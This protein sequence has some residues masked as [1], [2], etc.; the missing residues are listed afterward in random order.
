MAS[1]QHPNAQDLAAYALG[2][3]EPAKVAEIEFH[4]QM[5]PVCEAELRRL[6]DTR[7]QITNLAREA[8]TGGP[9]RLAVT[10]SAGTRLVDVPVLGTAISPIT[11]GRGTAA[12]LRVSDERCSRIHCRIEEGAD[13]HFIVD[14]GSAN[15]TLVNGVRS[16][17]CALRDGDVVNLGNVRI[18]YLAPAS[19]ATPARRE[20]PPATDEP[21]DRKQVASPLQ[22]PRAGRLRLVI[23]T[24]ERRWVYPWSGE[25]LRIGRSSRCD[26][27]LDDEN[28]SRKHLLLTWDGRSA[29]VKDLDTRNGTRLDGVALQEAVLSEGGLLEIGRTRLTFAGSGTLAV[30]VALQVARLEAALEGSDEVLAFELAT[31]SATIGRGR[32]A[33]IRIEHASLSRIHCEVAQTPQGLR[34]RDLESRNGTFLDG[35]R[36]QNGLLR[37]GQSLR[38][39]QVTI[40]YVDPNAAPIAEEVANT[41]TAVL[42]APRVRSVVR[43]THRSQN[44]TERIIG[45]LAAAAAVV[46]LGVI[47]LRTFKS[48]QREALARGREVARSPE[49][50]AAASADARRAATERNIQE[51]YMRLGQMARENP[52]DH[53]AVVISYR[54]FASTYPGHLLATEALR[55]AARWETQAAAFQERRFREISLEVDQ[56]LGMQDFARA[57]GYL[58]DYIDACPGTPMFAQVNE[59]LGNMDRVEHD[60]YGIER[61]R[62]E[63]IAAS[64]HPAEAEEAMRPL[65]ARY[66]S[67]DLVQQTQSRMADLRARREEAEAQAR[68]AAVEAQRQQETQRIADQQRILETRQSGNERIAQALQADLE[69]WNALQV[70]FSSK[71]RGSFR[72]RA[73]TERKELFGEIVALRPELNT[74]LQGQILDRHAA[75]MRTFHARLNSGTIRQ[76]LQSFD[77]DLNARRETALTL[78]MDERAY[79]YPDQEP[80][81][82]EVQREV[83]GLVAAVEAAYWPGMALLDRVDGFDDIQGRLREIEGYLPYCSQPPAETSDAAVQTLFGDLDVKEYLVVSEQDRRVLDE[84]DRIAKEIGLT[85]EEER[86]IRI[87]NEYRIRMGRRALRIAPKLVQTARLHSGDMRDNEYFSHTGRDGSTPGQRAARQGHTGPISENIYYGSASGSDS[88]EAWKHS[89]GHHRN[90]LMPGWTVIGVGQASTHWTMMPGN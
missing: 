37:P 18:T 78:I 55:E 52:N 44:P 85:A 68:V 5:C 22:I 75:L 8:L 27:Q 12:T 11:I 25:P 24:P 56:A 20:P 48:V 1:Q 61:A 80:H 74:E 43:V 21:L 59:R 17:R 60:A 63:T 41:Q 84:N 33:A 54:D 88:F 28:C 32:A 16:P 46:V 14:E 51:R 86:C 6:R 39:G 76:A 70:E 82:S 89:S 10:D 65:L 57:R 38:C 42:R 29:R 30:D 23:E 49:R 2:E 69:R 53:S 35:E 64:G 77:G 36:I 73:V 62:V 7:V 13:G 26:L 34:V 66:G 87:T 9:A 19:A 4:R 47:G 58:R 40:T 79:P 3:A 45:S 31:S 90:M 72:E 50:E 71:L 15:G 81:K 83:D 67:P